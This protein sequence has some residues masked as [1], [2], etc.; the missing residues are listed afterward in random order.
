MIHE[1]NLLLET[2][3][4]LRQWRQIS[5]AILMS[6]VIISAISVTFTAHQIRQVYA[7]LQVISLNSDNL[8]SQYEKLLLEQ[9][10]WADYS[11]IDQISRKELAMRSPNMEN[12][13]IVKR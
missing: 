7:R 5:V 6:L 13:V 2:I 9:S 4:W 10:A 3:I 12:M 1:K 11:R 8:E